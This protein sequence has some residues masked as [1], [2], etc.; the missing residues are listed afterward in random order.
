MRIL[1]LDGGIS[2]I[3]WTI[4]DI[5]SKKA[6]GHIVSADS[7]MFH[8]PEETA[9]SGPKL[10]NAERRGYRGQQHV[11]RRRQQRLDKLRW[12][13]GCYDLISTTIRIPTAMRMR[14][15]GPGWTHGNCAL[16]PL[17]VF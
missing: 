8:S 16:L 14:W 7:W 12:L 4:V 13:L 5:E 6:Q 2:S 17:S 15:R 11:I 3:G 10:K 1:G 9:Q